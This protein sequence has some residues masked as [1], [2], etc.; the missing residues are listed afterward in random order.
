MQEINSYHL[1]WAISMPF[2]V[3][4]HTNEN[5]IRTSENKFPIMEVEFRIKFKLIS[6]HFHSGLILLMITVTIWLTQGQHLLYMTACILHVGEVGVLSAL[7][8]KVP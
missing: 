5:R 7:G 8:S 6:M 4:F 2:P 1:D 3:E